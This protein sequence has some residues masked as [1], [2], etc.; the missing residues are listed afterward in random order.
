VPRATLVANLLIKEMSFRNACESLLH[1][2]YLGLYAAQN[3]EATDSGAFIFQ[4]AFR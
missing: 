3:R 2:Q 1:V 4:N